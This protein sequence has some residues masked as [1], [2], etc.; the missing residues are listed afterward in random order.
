M[1]SFPFIYLILFVVL[2]SIVALG[3][4]KSIKKIIASKYYG[5]VR[6]MIML[7]HLAVITC[8]IF[9][10]LYP[11]KLQSDLDYHIYSCFNAILFIIFIV[12]IP[13]SFSLILNYIF[14]DRNNI[15][16][17]M[18]LIISTGIGLAMIYGTLF[19][20]KDINVNHIDLHFNDLPH[21]FHN[22]KIIQISDIH[23]GNS[24]YSKKIIE[25]TNKKLENIDSDLLLFTGDLVNNF[26]GELKGFVN[27]FRE[28][29][30]EKQCYSILGNHDYGNYTEWDSKEKK[31]KNFNEI[32]SY[33]KQLGF[34]LLRNEH[35]IIKKQ[36]D[37]I[38]LIG[39]ENWGHPPFPRYADLDAAMRGIPQ[40]AFT[41]LIT[42]DP[43]HW[44]SKVKD[45]KDIDLTLSGHSHGFQW[46]IKP[47]GITFSLA[48]LTVC[49]W[50]GL[51]YNEKGILYV[52]TGLGTV[53]VPWRIDMPAEI[54]VFT[55]KRGKIDGKQE[56]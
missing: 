1:R 14:Q 45:K 25:K 46:G 38:F 9:L 28:F 22:Y 49:H 12:N 51:Y 30:A 34:N 17:C 27:N 32:L 52:N 37:S 4:L 53:G 5:F 7:V 21:E 26:S 41:I 44:E 15:I 16:P 19:G 23:F 42:H 13:L 47:A 11:R 56:L 43:A 20:V 35:I 10:Y 33:N 6:I 54:T 39:T 55:L 2:Y 18:G 48:Y 3:A 24:A 8:F 40:E 29:T 50:G 31:Q 36:K